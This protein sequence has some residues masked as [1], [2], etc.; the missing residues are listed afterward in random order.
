[1]KN[2]VRFGLLLMLL[3]ACLPGGNIAAAEDVK[4]LIPA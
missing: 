2:P 1:M 4:L 3:G